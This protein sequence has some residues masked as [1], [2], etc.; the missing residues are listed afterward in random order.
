VF[1]HLLTYLNTV[2]VCVL[3]KAPLRLSNAATRSPMF[4]LLFLIGKFPMTLPFIPLLRE[5]EVSHELCSL[6]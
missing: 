3:L 5:G 1:C 4:F 6:A 2:V